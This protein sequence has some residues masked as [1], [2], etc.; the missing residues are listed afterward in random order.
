MTGRRVAAFCRVQRNTTVRT[1]ALVY[2]S[3]NEH[4][5]RWKRLTTKCADPLRHTAQS[6]VRPRNRRTHSH[7]YKANVHTHTHT[8]TH[9]IG[10]HIQEYTRYKTQRHQNK[11][12]Q[13]DTQAHK[14]I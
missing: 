11:P 2:I 12:G 8:Y 4:E 9:K 7:D 5:S 1:I 6:Y 14:L 13:K 3:A 10:V